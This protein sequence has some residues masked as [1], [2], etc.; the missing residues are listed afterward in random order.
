LEI[1]KL[2]KFGNN[3]FVISLPKT[4]VIKNKLNKGSILYLSNT[5]NQIIVTP[6][7]G[8]RENKEKEI[9]L[10]FREESME[11]VRRK[12]IACY[13]NNYK[14][15]KILFNGNESAR[16]IR[17]IIQN[18]MA[19]EVIEQSSNLIIAKDYLNMHDISI[20]NLIRKSDTIVRTML[21]DMITALK[22]NNIHHNQELSENI[23]Q[24]DSDINRLTFLIMRTVKYLITE[25]EFQKEGDMQ[26]YLNFYEMSQNLE[27]I[28]DE[29]KRIVRYL[30]TTKIKENVDILA[31]FLDI[32][33]FYTNTMKAY[34]SKDPTS[35]YKVALEKNPL[36]DKIREFQDKHQDNMSMSQMLEMQRRVVTILNNTLRLV[37]Q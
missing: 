19:L 34:H 36:M 35:G 7:K 21:A 13:I 24:R 1:R 10:D 23:L 8:T 27:S 11:N 26:D 15:M 32:E 5:P 4:W 33:K 31:V 22:Q 28:G 37:Y 20:V 16:Q 3:S 9:T 18:L 2:I 12:V 14:L 29:C 25:P 6:Q 30:T 17:E